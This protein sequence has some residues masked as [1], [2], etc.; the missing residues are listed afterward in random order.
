[1]PKAAVVPAGVVPR[2][3]YAYDM[4]MT[5]HV[6]LNKVEM[7][8]P[9][10]PWHIYWI[11][12]ILYCSGCL[13]LMRWVHIQ[14]VMDM[15]ILRMHSRSHLSFLK[16]T[17]LMEKPSLIAAQSRH[18]DVYLCTMSD[19]CAHLSASRLL[20]LCSRVA[21]R[22]LD[23]GIAIVWL[24]GHHACRSKSMGFCLLNNIGIA[25]KDLQAGSP[26]QC[27]LIVDWDVH[28]G[29]GIQ[30][31]F[32]TDPTVL[33][34]SL[35]RYGKGFF[36]S[37]EAGNF[38]QLGKGPSKGY[39]INVPWMTEGVGD[40]NYL[41]AFCKLILPVAREFAPEMVIVT[42]G[43]DATVCNPIWE[44]NVMPECYAMMM[45]M[46]KDVCPKIVLSLEG[47]YNFEA[48]ANSAL[49]CAKALLDI[50]W[51]AGLVP[52]AAMVCDYAMVSPV[53]MR[54]LEAPR[55]TYVPV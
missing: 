2:V 42:C 43:F 46:L 51:Q 9:E 16:T 44:C 5:Y 40:G 15:Q 19:Y 29:N 48:I 1:N 53:E 11:Y 8:H 52:E 18:K 41:Y 17:E 25:I 20:A 22:Q 50:K 12:D 4:R 13:Q 23:S 54:G 30:E 3:G 55:A 38:T 7:P 31:L 35:H 28:H 39:N 14:P 27:I 10:D 49:A 24:P 33:Y 6:N 47:G 45:A 34:I 37:G 32:Y 26:M 36:L 21:C